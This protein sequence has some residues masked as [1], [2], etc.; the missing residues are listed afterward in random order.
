[1]RFWFGVLIAMG[2]GGA[3]AI[4][5]DPDGLCGATRAEIREE[6]LAHRITPAWLDCVRTPGSYIEP[7]HGRGCYLP[8]RDEIGS[9]LKREPDK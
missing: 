1:M 9:L 8:K 4:A 3:V 6:V 2:L 7:D 5:A